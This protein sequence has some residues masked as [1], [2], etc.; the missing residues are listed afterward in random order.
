SLAALYWGIGTIAAALVTLGLVPLASRIRTRALRDRQQAQLRVEV[1]AARENMRRI[2]QL[3]EGPVEREGL[4]LAHR[5]R[6]STTISGDF[7][8][9]IPRGDGTLGIYLVDIEGHGLRA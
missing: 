1:Q 2:L 8:N 4:K 9:V 6:Q 7:Y 5:L 3:P